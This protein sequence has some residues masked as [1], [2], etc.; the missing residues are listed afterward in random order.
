[1]KA[2]VS[3]HPWNAKSMSTTGARRLGECKRKKRDIFMGVKKTGF[4][5]GGHK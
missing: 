3:G 5:E 2:T 4:C 1:M